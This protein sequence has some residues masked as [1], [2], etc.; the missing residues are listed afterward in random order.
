MLRADARSARQWNNP[1]AHGQMRQRIERKYPSELV[2]TPTPYL[3]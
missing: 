2:A 3:L 1:P